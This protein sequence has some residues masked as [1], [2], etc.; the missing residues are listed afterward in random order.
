MTFDYTISAIRIGALC[1]LLWH[2]LACQ[3]APTERALQQQVETALIAYPDVQAHVDGREVTLTGTVTSDDE[4]R[5]AESATKAADSKYIR[6][7]VN[8]IAVS[9]AP[10]QINR[11]D[12]EMQAEAI[13]L[14]EDIPQVEVV[15]AEGVIG[16]TGKLSAS[17]TEDLKAALEEL[18]PKAIDLSGL[19]ID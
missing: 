6:K 8:K 15:V 11:R 17:K 5:Q 2:I 13:K 7:V 12:A 1:I 3:S 19:T 18:N 16:L 9:S 10:G 4:R 14:V